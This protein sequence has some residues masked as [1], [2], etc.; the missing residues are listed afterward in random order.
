VEQFGWPGVGQFGWPPGN[1][2]HQL[3]RSS[4]QPQEKHHAPTRKGVAD[5]ISSAVIFKNQQVCVKARSNKIMGLYCCGCQ[6]R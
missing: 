5:G 3:A 6:L 2:V 1:H 4:C